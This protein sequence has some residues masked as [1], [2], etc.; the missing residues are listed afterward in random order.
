MCLVVRCAYLCADVFKASPS[1]TKAGLDW[2]K[3]AFKV[4]VVRKGITANSAFVGYDNLEKRIAVS[5][6]LFLD[7]SSC[8]TAQA[9]TRVVVDDFQEKRG[10]IISKILDDAKL[11]GV[12]SVVCVCV[13]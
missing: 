8:C 5:P 6:V 4:N 12:C 11:E 13:C 2:E 9:E 1:A 10:L 7:V 3:V